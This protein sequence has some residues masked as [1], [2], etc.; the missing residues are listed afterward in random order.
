MSRTTCIR[1]GAAWASSRKETDF[2]LSPATEQ[3]EVRSTHRRD[4]AD[5]AREEMMVVIRKVFAESGALD[6][7]TAVRAIARQLGF[8][9]TGPR[10]DDTVR[11][12]LTVAVRRRKSRRDD[13]V[14]Q[15]HK[16]QHRTRQR[17]DQQQR[18]GVALFRLTRQGQNVLFVAA[19]R[20]RRH[21]GTL[22]LL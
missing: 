21:A 20:G 18:H 8:A 4:I 14:A 15:R 10:I 3:T 17:R 19:S 6:T 12:N 7:E 5:I 16:D 9:R 22:S 11:K 13:P 1:R 2:S